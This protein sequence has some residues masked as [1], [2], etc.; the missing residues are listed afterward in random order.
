MKALRS[1]APGGP[2]TLT[3]D[4]VADP[5]P[6]DRDVLIR[7]AACAVNFPDLLMVADKYQFRPPRPFAP[8][9]EVS[10][11]VERVGGGVS[12]FAPG[13][14]VMALCSLGGMAEKLVVDA[15]KCVLVPDF[16][17]LDEAAALQLTYGTA[18]YAIDVCGGLQTG[19]TA[20]V[21]GAAGGVGLAGVE[22]CRALGARVV[23]AVSSPEKAD[24]AR[25]RGADETVE[26]PT[27]PLDRDARRA[28]AVRL[29]EAYGGPHL[30]L[31]PVGG[32]YTEAALRAIR[33]GGRLAVIGF[34]A[35]IPAVPLNL[36]LLND[37]RIIAAAWGAVVARDPARFQRT[38]QG[39][40]ELY[41]R[42]LIH[43]F[44]SK[45]LPL[46]RGADA[47]AVIESRAAT[48]KIL[49]EVDPSL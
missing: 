34:A 25:S 17:P 4:E 12:G 45:R 43:P 10:G 5:V 37:A 24:L 20:L 41:Q 47:L 3:L 1:H 48:G 33:P 29:R 44:I 13:D 22:L 7:V 14:R 32:D 28:L 40:L 23:A 2:L 21:L 46:E 39:L 6:G 38:I 16:L 19:E 30:V 11:I 36:V 31:D 49:I 8:G 26:Y 9:A 35:G 15:D 42:K 27:G 18:F